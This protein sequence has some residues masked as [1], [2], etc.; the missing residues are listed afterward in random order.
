MSFSVKVPSCA[1]FLASWSKP[2]SVYGAMRSNIPVTTRPER[3]LSFEDGN[4]V[5]F[6]VV[7]RSSE[8]SEQWFMD[9]IARRNCPKLDHSWG[10]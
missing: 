1:I 6:P 2:R 5:I 9:L 4:C 3:S 10:G 8:K 7:E